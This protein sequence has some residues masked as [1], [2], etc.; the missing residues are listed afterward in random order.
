MIYNTKF[1]TDNISYR[2][3]GRPFQCPIYRF[4]PTE[5]SLAAAS[6]KVKWK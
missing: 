5:G 1:R 6:S 3:V 4:F 2:G